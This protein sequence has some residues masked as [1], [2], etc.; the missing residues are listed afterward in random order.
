MILSTSVVNPLCCAECATIRLVARQV[1]LGF[2]RPV[3]RVH[4]P[5]ET[6]AQGQL[7]S[8]NVLRKREAA[9]AWCD[10]INGLAAEHRSDCEW[11]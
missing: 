3:G 11:H 1:E 10:R 8:P 6:K 2:L 7:A 9:V 5:G 4:L